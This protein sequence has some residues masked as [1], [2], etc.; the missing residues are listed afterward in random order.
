MTWTPT[1]SAPST[2][3]RGSCRPPPTT[4]TANASTPPR[5]SPGTVGRSRRRSWTS[6][7]KSGAARPL[8]RQDV[9]QAHEGDELQQ[10]GRRVDEPHLATVPLRSEL[11]AREGVDRDRIGV[12]PAHSAIGEVRAATLEEPANTVAEPGQI[13]PGDGAFDPEDDRARPV[14][15]HL[16]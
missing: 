14:Q 12:D 8:I 3:A 7:L 15:G 4:P 11:Q 2:M 1:T 13:C 9:A 16:G 5:I 10:L 6:R